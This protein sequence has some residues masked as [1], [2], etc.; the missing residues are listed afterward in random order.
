MGGVE[1]VMA[2]HAR[3]FLD[4]GYPVTV[5]AGR[6]EKDVLPENVNVVVIP[7][8]DTQHPEIL[9]INAAL[10]E[11]QIP[12]T[13]DP[14][15]ER[16]LQAL[17]PLLS[18][19]D[20]VIVHNIFT[21]H[22]NLPL[23]AALFNLLDQGVIGGPNR[24]CLAWC[25]DLTWTSPNS[26]S[27]V[28]PG[29]PW[30]LLRTF[31]PNIHY[32][33]VSEQRQRELVELLEQPAGKIEVIYNGVEPSVWYGLTPEGEDLLHRLD[34]LSGDLILL[35]PVRVTQAKNVELAARVV[36]VLKERGCNPRLVVT[37]PPD[38]HSENRMV[39]YRSLLDLRGNLGL[40]RELIFIFGFGIDPN[41]P[42]LIS[43]QVVA[44]LLRVSDVLFMP[45]HREGFGMPVLEAGLIGV[46]VVAADHIPAA[47]EIGG[48][49]VYL[50]DTNAAPDDIAR[51]ILEDATNQPS[52]RF[53]RRVRQNFTWE[54]IFRN[55]IEPAL[56]GI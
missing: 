3:V 30:D 1:A 26:R 15:R 42:Y 21:K 39:Y 33:A 48:K 8:M 25:H 47:R 54:R 23:T 2:A 16:L 6:A 46:P 52:C 34:L 17:R 53:R 36:A 44:D 22:F 35:M 4:A 31:H 43:Q 14:L 27:K 32:I 11:G 50:F 28:F 18:D 55:K 38:P 41:E 24:R 56:Q 51:L 19:F 7:E 12:D 20:A 40:E 5:I 9:E 29:Y 49:N 10:E 13:F 45:S 37:G